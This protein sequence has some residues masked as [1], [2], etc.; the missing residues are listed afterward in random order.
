VQRR[1]VNPWSWQ[2]SFGFSRAIGVH[3][4]GMR[5]QINQAR[6]NLETVLRESGAGLSD[7][8]RLNYYTTD[9]ALLLKASDALLDRL[10][11]AGCQPASTLVGVT[12]LA[13]PELLV[14]IE[15]TA[16]V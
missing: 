6:G 7:V 2:D 8:V 16:V 4:N 13:F 14:E 9:V 3:F 15:A 10:W 1:T 12:S 11:E 5:G